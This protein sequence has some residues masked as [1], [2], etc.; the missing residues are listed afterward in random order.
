MFYCFHLNLAKYRL[1]ALNAMA[2]TNILASYSWSEFRANYGK[3][4]LAH[5][6]D[7]SGQPFTK[8][9]FV[10]A[11]NT[12][13]VGFSS[14]L[15]TLSAEEIIRRKEEFQIVK[16]VTEKN[17]EGYVYKLCLKGDGGWEDLE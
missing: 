7:D 2:T 17:K 15:G 1:I 13:F 12:V 8:I 10:G 3:P 14:K 4:K 16:H 6:K 9:A 11:T 5:F